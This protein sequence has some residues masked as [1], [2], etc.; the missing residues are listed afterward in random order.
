[1]TSKISLVLLVLCCITSFTACS[2]TPASSTPEPNLPNPASAYCEQQGYKLE[3]RTADDGSQS[4]ICIFPDGNSCDEWA[5]YRGECGPQDSNNLT[6]TPFPVATQKLIADKLVIETY[7]LTG[8]PNSESLQF[9]SVQGRI[10]GPSD[11]EISTPFP[12]K[13]LDGVPLRYAVTL[14]NDTLI[15]EESDQTCET[16]NCII[17]TRNGE[18]IFRT[19]A[20]GIS[21][22]NALQNLW[23]YDDHWVL[24]TNLFLTEK[25]FNGQ[26]F[27]DG[28]SLN[29]EY[30]YEET[31]NFQTING[32]PFY[33]FRLDGKVSA[34]FDG[35]EIPLGYDDVIHY[36]C[37]SDSSLNPRARQGA[38][39]FFGTK[40]NTWYFV[41]I[42]APDV[43][44]KSK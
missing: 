8:P 21:P 11:F 10:F 9:T 38:V 1:M 27:V 37:C 31:F 29:Q 43:L 6:N 17:V 42:I 39:L 35:Q 33:F 34:W 12:S 23:T 30:G 41:Q 28:T 3:I 4:G 19:D 14:N 22:I 7:E 16:G 44:E 15:A 18:E 5:Y 40:G 20:G 32:R 26:I 2:F 13:Q 36:R 24:E 25:P